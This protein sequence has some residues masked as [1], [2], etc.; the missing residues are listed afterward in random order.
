MAEPTRPTLAATLGAWRLSEVGGK[1]GCRL[2]LTAQPGIGGLEVKVPIA[3]R[4]A[5]P[6]LKAVST[7]SFDADGAIV[8]SDPSQ[9][10]VLVFKAGPSHAYDAF[11]PGG[12]IWRLEPAG[13]ARGAMAP[14][15]LNGAFRLTGAQ[16]AVLCDLTLRPDMFGVS[17]EITPGPCAAGWTDKVFATWALKNGRLTLSDR[18]RKPILVLRPGEGGAFVTDDPKADPISLAPRPGG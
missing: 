9:H 3:C 17:G 4:R 12:K 11:A 7:W 13:F 15:R 14:P 1:V 16:G 10:R 18:Q 2:N 6:A 5:F 8:L